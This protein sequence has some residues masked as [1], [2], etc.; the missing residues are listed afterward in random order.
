MPCRPCFQSRSAPRHSTAN[1]LEQRGAAAWLVSIDARLRFVGR[2]VHFRG[3]RWRGGCRTHNAS[4]IRSTLPAFLPDWDPSPMAGSFC[5]RCVRANPAYAA[6][7][8]FVRAAHIWCAAGVSCKPLM[9]P[10]RVRVSR[11]TGSHSSAEAPACSIAI[12]LRSSPLRSLQEI[13]SITYL[14]FELPGR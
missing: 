10:M 1:R 3:R 8:S 5:E 6:A 11:A 4:S 12:A 14:P 7:N 2:R 9:R 13:P